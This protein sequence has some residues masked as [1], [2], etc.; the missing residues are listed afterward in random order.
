MFEAAFPEH[1]K[2]VLAQTYRS[3]ETICTAVNSLID[4]NTERTK[5]KLWTENQQGTPIRVIVSHDA[6][7]EVEA[8]MASDSKVPGAAVTRWRVVQQEVA[9]AV[10]GSANRESGK[11]S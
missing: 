7:K 3:T 11:S 1:S 6:G 8:V 2:I 5:K 4:G 9:E 10:K